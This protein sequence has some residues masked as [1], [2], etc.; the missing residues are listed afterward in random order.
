MS[1]TVVRSTRARLRATRY[2]RRL[3]RRWPQHSVN[4]PLCQELEPREGVV[5]HH[6]SMSS[7]PNL[8][9]TTQ[10]RHASLLGDMLVLSPSRTRPN[11]ARDATP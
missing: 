7:N 2:G 10:F 1:V 9:R 8:V 6:V 4:V 11:P 5:V 3:C